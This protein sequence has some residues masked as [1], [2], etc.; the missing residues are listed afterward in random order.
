MA[1]DASLF[2]FAAHVLFRRPTETNRERTETIRSRRL[3]V[4]FISFS[5][6][7]SRGRER[8]ATPLRRTRSNY[9]VPVF[10]MPDHR[11]AQVHYAHR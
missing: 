5:T 11:R 3:R 6:S 1:V 7:R 4:H 10:L 9:Y 8:E 2:T